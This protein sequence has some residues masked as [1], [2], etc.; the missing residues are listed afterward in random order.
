MGNRTSA[1]RNGP[2]ILA[3][4]VGGTGLKASVLDRAGK[5]LVDRVRVATPYPCP[6]KVLLRTLVALVHRCLGSIEFPWDF[7]A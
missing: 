4:D 6:P 1:F 3:I 7:L 5:M 2:R